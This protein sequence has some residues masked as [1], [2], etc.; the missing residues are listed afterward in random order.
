MTK[1]NQELKNTLIKLRSDGLGAKRI[2]KEM[3]VSLATIKR[4]LDKI[5]LRGT[6][7]EYK[8]IQDKII[9]T[10][11]C[12]SCGTSY[13]ARRHHTQ[14]CS[15]ICRIR[16]FK[17]ENPNKQTCQYCEGI[18]FNYR[19]RRF[20]SEQCNHD[21]YERKELIRRLMIALKPKPTRHCKHCQKI[22]ILDH[23]QRLFCS[24]Y[25][26]Y[27]YNRVEEVY[28]KK[29]FE[30]G[31]HFSTTNNNMRFCSYSCGR[32]FPHR[33]RNIRRYKRMKENGPIDWNISIERLLH[34]DGYKCYLCGD[35]MDTRGDTNGDYYPSID[36]VIPISKGGTHTWK[37]VKLAHRLCNSYKADEIID[38]HENKSEQLT[39][40]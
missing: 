40:F 26:R 1:F 3:N 11:Q 8:P 13:D 17:K 22:F 16:Y 37:N 4:W 32:K 36:H 21:Y 18:F 6:L 29:C 31:R 7:K 24:D 9:K 38:I 2:S 30:C 39:L 23:G 5:G 34:R 27:K 12:K 14:F 28:Q 20:C 19:I 33:A 25:C 10:I 15:D 35:K